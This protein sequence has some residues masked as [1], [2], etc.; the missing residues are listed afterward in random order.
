MATTWRTSGCRAG[1]LRQAY[2]PQLCPTT[3][4]AYPAYAGSAF[5]A[6]AG[7]QITQRLPQTVGTLPARLHA[8]GVVVGEHQIPPAGEQL[9]LLQIGT[10]SAAQ[11]VIE[12]HHAAGHWLPVMVKAPLQHMPHRR[13]EGI[14]LPHQLL[15]IRR[16]KIER[17]A[18]VVDPS[19]QPPA[20]ERLHP[21]FHSHI[22]FPPSYRFQP[23]GC[24]RLPGCRHSVLP[25]GFCRSVPRPLAKQPPA[26]RSE[27]C[28]RRPRPCGSA[29]KA[30][31]GPPFGFAPP[32]RAG[33][34]RHRGAR[35][36]KRLFLLPIIAYALPFVNSIRRK[37]EKSAGR[38]FDDDGSV[39]S[40]R[41]DSRV[42]PP[43]VAKQHK[44]ACDVMVGNSPF[45]QQSRAGFAV[46]GLLSPCNDTG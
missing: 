31:G 3:E 46:K 29:P 26:A 25:S 28:L 45:P 20:I 22:R 18:R 11:A 8:A 32:Q 4:I 41:L 39:L 30:G 38:S 10:V 15:E 7:V 21:F 24:L 35:P 23:S 16:R 1:M 33:T 27:Y 5:S 36:K 42:I 19:V 17:R 43:A 40:A 12:H 14:R 13:A 6:Q 34:D 44:T 2:A 9:H 37:S